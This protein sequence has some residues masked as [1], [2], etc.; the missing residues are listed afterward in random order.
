MEA[1]VLES[2]GEGE[3]KG[4]A[5]PGPLSLGFCVVGGAV[6]RLHWVSCADHAMGMSAW[7]VSWAGGVGKVNQGHVLTWSLPSTGNEA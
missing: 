7:S 1:T 4:E 2:R 6:S 5:R 3:R